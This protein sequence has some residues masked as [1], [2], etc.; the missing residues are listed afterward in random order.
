MVASS[1]E[2]VWHHAPLASTQKKV[3]KLSRATTE[4]PHLTQAVWLDCGSKGMKVKA[5]LLMQMSIGVDAF[6]PRQTCHFWS[7][8]FHFEKDHAPL[9]IGH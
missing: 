5:A 3:D 7:G 1:V 4:R 2:R 8:H 6:V 9:H